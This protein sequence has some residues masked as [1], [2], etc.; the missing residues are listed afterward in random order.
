M[1][2]S[3]LTCHQCLVLISVRLH[4]DQHYS[5]SPDTGLVCTKL[6]LLLRRSLLWNSFLLLTQ[7]K[8][9][10]SFTQDTLFCHLLTC[11]L[12]PANERGF[13]PPPAKGEKGHSD[14]SSLPSFPLVLVCCCSPSKEKQK[15]QRVLA[16]TM[17]IAYFQVQAS[18]FGSK[19]KPF[20]LSQCFFTELALT[21][22]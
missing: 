3:W 9:S 11:V 7:S 20:T 6:L 16:K 13:P 1:V 18:G 5:W 17:P 19:V 2:K 4:P 10:P 14:G 21:V 22:V 12:L 15:H 8:D